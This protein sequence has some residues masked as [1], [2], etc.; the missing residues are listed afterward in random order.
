M[1][2]SA[3]IFCLC[4]QYGNEDFLSELITKACGEWLMVHTVLAAVAFLT[5]I[6]S[7]V[8]QFQPIK[9]LPHQHDS[10]NPLKCTSVGFQWVWRKGNL[11]TMSV[12]LNNKNY[13]SMVS[14]CLSSYG[15]T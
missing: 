2:N 4:F 12:L 6:D 1:Q 13:C 10:M 9:F 3:L 8:T 7:K 11:K 14:K 15:C 5:L